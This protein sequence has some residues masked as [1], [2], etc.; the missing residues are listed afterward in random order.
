MGGLVSKPQKSDLQV[1]DMADKLF[2]FM[3]TQYDVNEIWDIAEKPSEYILELSELIHHHFTVIGY[4][5]GAGERGEIYVKKIDEYKRDMTEVS[6]ENRKQKA[7]EREERRRNAQT[8]AFFFVR[9]FQILG[10]MLLVI[11]DTPIIAEDGNYLL[12]K[13]RNP[14]LPRVDYPTQNIGLAKQQELRAE[15]LRLQARVNALER[16][17]APQTGGSA[18]GGSVQTGGALSSSFTLGS[19]ECFRNFLSNV[20][21]QEKQRVNLTKYPILYSFTENVYLTFTRQPASTARPQ[22]TLNLSPKFIFLTPTKVEEIPITSISTSPDAVSTG[23][24]PTLNL[25]TLPPVG[26]SIKRF[27]TILKL[28]Y[29][30]RAVETKQKYRIDDPDLKYIAVR[31]GIPY[32]ITSISRFVEAYML[33]YLDEKTPGTSTEPKFTRKI[34]DEEK[35]TSYAA[36]RTGLIHNPKK[37]PGV[38]KSTYEVLLNKIGHS[39]CKR[40][41]LQLLD[42]RSILYGIDNVDQRHAPTTDICAYSAPPDEEGKGK[43]DTVSLSEYRPTESLGQLFGKISR[44]RMDEATTVLKAFVREKEGA[45]LSLYG[46]S[47]SL[48]GVKDGWSNEDAAMASTLQRLS[49]VFESDTS[50]EITGFKDLKMSRSKKCKTTERIKL[51]SGSNV[52]RELR[53]IA[54]QLIDKHNSSLVYITE[55]L[56]KLFSIDPATNKVSGIKEEILLLGLSGLDAL[57]DQARALLTNYYMDCETIF[58]KGVTTWEASVEPDASSTA[59]S[60]VPSD[61]SSDAS[62]TAPLPNI[63]NAGRLA[64]KKR[65]AAAKLAALS[66]EAK[67]LFESIRTMDA[68]Q[69]ATNLTIVSNKFKA[70]EAEARDLSPEERQKIYSD[71][72]LTTAN[73]DQL[74]SGATAGTI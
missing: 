56:E 5:G 61:A 42:A 16:G 8:I 26:R 70:G 11:R 1:K 48:M 13:R 37:L 54:Q 15:A 73:L 33:Y 46:K 25:F 67:T 23:E 53:A 72:G 22:E 36:S 39:H 6:E 2:T 9:V 27:N 21:D 49:S 68:T 3:Y 62:S 69:Y 60:I 45:D 63:T 59:S 7:I 28:Q 19:F 30:E 40:R 64:A 18:T 43:A 57:T 38:I 65:A 55:Y 12:E 50:S 52:A 31:S 41:A 4:T 35:T 34:T 51:A 71:A 24:Y 58:Q 20:T 44:A 10:A 74:R 17:A 66:I 29:D 32:P 14:Q 47:L